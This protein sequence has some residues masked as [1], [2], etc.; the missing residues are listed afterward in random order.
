MTTKGNFDRFK[1]IKHIT[2]AVNISNPLFRIEANER[3]DI[4]SE[5]IDGVHY[6]ISGSAY[7]LSKGKSYHH[8]TMLLELKLD[9]LGRLLHRDET[10]LGVVDAMSSISSVKW[11]VMNLE[12]DSEKFIKVVSD[13]FKRT[14]GVTDEQDKEAHEFNDMLGLLDFMGSVP[15]TSYTIDETTELPIE[16][17]QTA[18]ELKQWSWKFGHTP[19]FTHL[20]TNKK[21]NFTILFNVEQGSLKKFELNFMNTNDSKNKEIEQSFQYLALHIKKHELPYTGRNVAGYVLND[22][23]SDWIGESIDGTV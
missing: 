7:K 3:G 20:L 23:I 9:V 5:E 13:E 19:K 10:K 11:K 17:E 6:K 15:V 2:S 14:Y 21:H 8:G 22:E 18:E 16:I 12:M 4:V 1:F